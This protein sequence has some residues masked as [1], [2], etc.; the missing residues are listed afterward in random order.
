ML[1]RRPYSISEPDAAI[2]VVSGGSGASPE[3]WFKKAEFTSDEEGPGF[4][5]ARPYFV[6]ACAAFLNE[7][8]MKFIE[9][10][11]AYRKSGGKAW[12][13]CAGKSNGKSKDFI[14]RVE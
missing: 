4:P 14:D 2:A 6:V 8:R 11:D 5:A 13:K 3:N 1:W 7:G 10:Y 9:P 12:N